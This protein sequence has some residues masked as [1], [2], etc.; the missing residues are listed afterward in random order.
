MLMRWLKK[1]PDLNHATVRL[2]T[3]HDITAVSLLLRN[4][5]RRYYGINGPDLPPLL[6]DA[7]A[8]VLTTGDDIQ[9][10]AISSYPLRG[11]LWLRAL[12][13]ARGIDTTMGV[14]TLLLPLHNTLRERAIRRI[15]YSGDE[16][17]DIWM[18][19]AL[20]Q[21][22]YVPDTD[23]MI[24]E[25]R[26]LHVPAQGN[27]LVHIRH[28]TPADL[29]AVE[30]LDRACFEVQWVKDS[31]TLSMALT[32][33]AFFVVAELG[34]H[35]VGYAFATSHFGGRLVHLVRIAVDPRRRGQAIG[36]RL[37]GEVIAYARPQ[38]AHVVTLNTQSHNQR[39]KR[40]YNWFG[41]IDTGERQPV[42]RYDL[43][44]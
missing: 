14:G 4:G 29:A 9:G 11:T 40:L 20:R 10:V 37:L 12:A 26:S 42:V 5:G 33:G 7:Q 32:Q 21:Y 35:I 19:P 24:Y 27:R 18:L 25:K 43:E 44:A 17:A 38:R 28:T 16:A 1:A 8:V 36:I 6:A 15:F 23:V 30:T 39:A 22:G 3:A 13:L 41:F 34:T 2:S 31:S